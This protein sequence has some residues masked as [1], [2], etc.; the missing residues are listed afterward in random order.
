MGETNPTY[1]VREIALACF[2]K[3]DLNGNERI[4]EGD[5]VAVRKPNISI[6]RK[7]ANIYLWL[8]LEGLEENEMA[9]LADCL[10]EPNEL[11]V[12]SGVPTGNRYDKRR[13]CIPF[14]RLKE[15]YPAFNMEKAR[16][17][18][19]VYQPFLGIDENDLFYFLTEEPPFSVSGLVFDKQ[20]GEYL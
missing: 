13:Y 16:D 3:P 20:T 5:I 8:R 4:Q 18:D 6:G 10:Y 2:S 14:D 11:N 9:R 17:P 19:V 1:P 15:V 7:E 12:E